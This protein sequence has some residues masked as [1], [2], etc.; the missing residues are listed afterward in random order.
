M[1]RSG[2]TLTTGQRTGLDKNERAIDGANGRLTDA[3]NEINL[4]QLGYAP[5]PNEGSYNKQRA[6]KAFDDVKRRAKLR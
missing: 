6:L 2:M 4:S 3:N 1:K 5:L